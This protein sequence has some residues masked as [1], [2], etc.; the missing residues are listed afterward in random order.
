MAH[1]LP[2]Y[3]VG[4]LAEG[5]ERFSEFNLR[6]TPAGAGS[7]KMGFHHD[8]ALGN[9]VNR[10]PYHPC[11]WLC[12]ICYL[13]DVGADEPAFAVVP[14]TVKFEPIEKAKKELGEDYEEVALY[15]PAGTCVFYDIATYH[16]RLDSVTGNDENGRRTMHEYYARGGYLDVPADPNGEWDAQTRPPTPLLTDWVKIPERMAMHEDPLKKLFFSHWN[17]GQCEWAALG[18]PPLERVGGNSIYRPVLPQ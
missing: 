13:T 18:F 5:N 16:T 3:V 12:S 9:R 14:K 2:S 10:K 15:G 1:L 6:D 11:D 7:M 4:V 17:V 8:A